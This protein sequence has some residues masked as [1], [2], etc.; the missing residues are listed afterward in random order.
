M[1]ASDATRLDCHRPVHYECRR[2]E[3]TVLYQTLERHLETFI[4]NVEADGE[5]TLPRFVE[6]ERSETSS[7]TAQERHRPRRGRPPRSHSLRVRGTTAVV[8]LRTR[9]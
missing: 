7:I 3:Q 1:L 6:K 9:K 2:P 4:A 5:R 8:M